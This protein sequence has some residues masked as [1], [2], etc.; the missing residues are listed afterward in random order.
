MAKKKR[1]EVPV[2]LYILM[3]QKEK[4]DSRSFREVSLALECETFPLLIMDAIGLLSTS[5]S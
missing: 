5:A 3:L 1:P 2:H 4:A